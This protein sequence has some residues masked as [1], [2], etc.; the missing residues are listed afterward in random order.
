MFCHGERNKIENSFL[1]VEAPCVFLLFSSQVREDEKK[2]IPRRFYHY[3][4][5]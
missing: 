1:F 2:K 5:T 3:K 4:S